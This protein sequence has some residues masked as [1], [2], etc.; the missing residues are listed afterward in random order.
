M[1]RFSVVDIPIASKRSDCATLCLIVLRNS[2]ISIPVDDAPK[3]RCPVLMQIVT[4]P[5]R[6]YPF[7]AL[8]ICRDGDLC[9][10]RHKRK[11][12]ELSPVHK[13]KVIGQT[14]SSSDP[15]AGA[16]R[17]MRDPLN[18]TSNHDYC[19]RAKR[20]LWSPNGHPA[21]FQTRS[22]SISSQALLANLA[23]S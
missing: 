7:S 21:T 13:V 17:H 10:C 20:A 9:A 3:L 23:D 16:K 18:F 14:S 1:W 8:T 11:D 5:I 2:K 4:Q 6:M 19:V 22:A 15:S 12:N